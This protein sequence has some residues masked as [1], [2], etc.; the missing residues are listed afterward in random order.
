MTAILSHKHTFFK[1]WSYLS[2]KFTL[3]SWCNC[4]SSKLA[5]K[6]KDKERNRNMTYVQQ[7]DCNGL[8]TDDQVGRYRAIATEIQ[9]FRM[10]KSGHGKCHT[11]VEK[12]SPH[13]VQKKVLS[14]FSTLAKCSCCSKATNHD[15]LCYMY[16]LIP[17]RKKLVAMLLS[18]I[19][20]QL[21]MVTRVHDVSVKNQKFWYLGN[22]YG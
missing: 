18:N 2:C 10:D 9:V 21:V 22:L 17:C 14:L 3:S 20:M 5:F 13:N 19:N 7:H 1:A 12:C 11:A 8:C 16:L 4:L 15:C 6:K